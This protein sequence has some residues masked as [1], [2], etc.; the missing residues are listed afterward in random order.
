MRP[1][2]QRRALWLA[3]VLAGASAPVQAGSVTLEPVR[4]ELTSRRLAVSVQI[5]NVSPEPTTLQAHVT[6]WRAQGT[7]ESLTDSDDL[8]LN[9]PVFNL[10]PGQAQFMRVGLRR[11]TESPAEATYRLI[12]EEV[13]PPPR[14]GIT[15]VTTLLKISIPIFVNPITTPPDLVWASEQTEG[16]KIRLRVESRDR[17]HVQI[18]SLTVSGATS[19]KKFQTAGVTYVLPDGR[20]EWIIDQDAVS[21]SDKLFI[22]ATTDR[23]SVRAMVEPKTR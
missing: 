10:K 3:A 23:G 11:P 15:G 22:E 14:P 2:L 16:N 6:A 4:I 20:K 8:L 17:A 7:E 19:G 1:G 13:P 12:V 18:K 21:G 5:R 9:P